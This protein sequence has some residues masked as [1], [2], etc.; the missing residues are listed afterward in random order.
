MSI[1]PRQLEALLDA[2]AEIELDKHDPFEYEGWWCIQ[3]KPIEC[4]ACGSFM[5]YVEPPSV[6]LIVVWEEKDDSDML[7]LAARLK[8]INLDPIVIQFNPIMGSCVPFDEV[9][10]KS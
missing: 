10:K 3:H 7:R 4:E 8:N 1:M 5:C 9:K 2:L 6:H